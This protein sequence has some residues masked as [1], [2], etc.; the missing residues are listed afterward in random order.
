VLQVR[1]VSFLIAAIAATLLVAA[2]VAFAK[3]ERVNTGGG[4]GHATVT[5]SPFAGEGRS[6]AIQAC[7]DDG[8]G[9]RLVAWAFEGSVMAAHAQD[10]NGADNGCGRTDRFVSTSNVRVQV[11]LYDQSAHGPLD[12]RDPSEARNPN[13][14]E[15]RSR[16]FLG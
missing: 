1:R 7:D 16:T 12:I 8:D 13:L 10:S 15:C 2:P 9:F 11:C 14:A 3:R 4:G 5:T 6:V